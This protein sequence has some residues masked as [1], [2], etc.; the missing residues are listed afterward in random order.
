MGIASHMPRSTNAN[1]EPYVLVMVHM[2]PSE[3]SNWRWT[4]KSRLFVVD[5]QFILENCPETE[6]YRVRTINR[7]DF[8]SEIWLDRTK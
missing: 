6:P 1:S 2:S 5:D 7:K 4:P 3:I 8:L